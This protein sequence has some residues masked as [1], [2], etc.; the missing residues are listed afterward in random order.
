MKIGTDITLAQDIFTLMKRI[1][2]VIYRVREKKGGW[3]VLE[4]TKR[5]RGS[6]D[7]FITRRILGVTSF[8]Y[9]I[10]AR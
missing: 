3:W 9:G 8:R 7:V 6:R 2:D 4:E 10:M 5:R 1:V